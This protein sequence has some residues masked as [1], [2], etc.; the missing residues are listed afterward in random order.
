MTYLVSHAVDLAEETP[1]VCQFR[2]LEDCCRP[3]RH[4]ALCGA[5]LEGSAIVRVPP[6]R[7][8]VHEYLHH[9][10]T[11]VHNQAA[12]LRT[13]DVPDKQV[14]GEVEVSFHASGRPPSPLSNVPIDCI[15]PAEQRSVDR[16]LRHYRCHRSSYDDLGRWSYGCRFG[17]G[18]IPATTRRLFLRAHPGC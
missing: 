5:L 16:Q 2:L 12:R 6:G 14:Q 8:G 10:H 11:D 1:N 15:L 7:V 3:L 17:V 18:C 4:G 13:Q 9:L